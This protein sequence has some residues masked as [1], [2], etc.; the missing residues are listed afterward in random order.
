MMGSSSH[1]NAFAMLANLTT[2][3]TRFCHSSICPA[4]TSKGPSTPTPISI[5]LREILRLRLIEYNIYKYLGAWLEFQGTL[6]INH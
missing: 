3:T 5:D 6:L 1:V 4:R 2:G